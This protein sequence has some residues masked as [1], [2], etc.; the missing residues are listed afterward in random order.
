MPLL[1]TNIKSHIYQNKSNSCI[2][3]KIYID[4]CVFLGLIVDFH[5]FIDSLN[6]SF[7]QKTLV[8][9][10]HINE[11]DKKKIRNFAND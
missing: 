2:D 10:L 7:K 5:K 8:F 4:L 9:I 11:V 6:S 3:H 1:T